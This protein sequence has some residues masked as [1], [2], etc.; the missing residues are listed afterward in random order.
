MKRFEFYNPTRII[1]G[2]GVLAET[3]ATVAGY[4]TRALLVTGRE[5]LKKSGVYDTL[6]S[7]LKNAGV[8]II[9]FSGVRPNPL[10]SHAREGGRLA[11]AE[12]ADCIVAAGGGSV[13]DEAKAIAM[14]ACDKGPLWDFFT[15]KRRPQAAL[16]LIAVQT[17]PA[18][19]SEMNPA[20]VLTNDETREKFSCRSSLLNPAAALLDPE[21]TLSLPLDQTAYAGVDMISH[22]LEGY[23]TS[24]DPYAPVH[25]GYAEGLIRAI[26]D[27]L[28]QL[29]TDP[30]DLQ[31][32]SALMWA[33]SLAWNGLANAGLEGAAIPNHM[34][35]HP[36]SALYDLPHGAGLSVII[37]AWMKYMRETI[38]PRL[39]Q[40]GRHILGMGIGAGG[41]R[42]AFRNRIIEHWEEWYRHIGAPVR[43]GEAGIE[44]PDLNGLTR[45]A[46]AL[47]RL[48]GIKGYADADVEAIYRLAL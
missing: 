24:Q 2:A 36:V 25:D 4:G 13:I 14:A 31:A 43:F 5:S 40:F 44:S 12:K 46:L 34:L 15:R 18:T 23:L 10:L 42:E 38:A 1:F 3:G 35:E 37:P 30:R 8:D 22:L 9:D 28:E 27:S 29:L 32:R 11:A 7:S 20:A 21:T 45:Q 26:K 48:W 16:P 41:N 33:G 39:E 6:V 17:L 19:S 47:C